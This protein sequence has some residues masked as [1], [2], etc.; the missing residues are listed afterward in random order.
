MPRRHRTHISLHQPAMLSPCFCIALQ[1]NYITRTI[2]FCY[3]NPRFS[4]V[5]HSDNICRKTIF[6]KLHN[7]RYHSVY[8]SDKG[9]LEIQRLRRSNAASGWSKGTMCLNASKLSTV[10]NIPRKKYTPS[11]EDSSECNVSGSEPS[12]ACATDRSGELTAAE[13][14]PWN[15]FRGDVLELE[16]RL[17]NLKPALVAHV[18]THHI[19]ESVR[20]TSERRVRE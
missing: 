3:L 17:Q 8:S 9:V 10:T 20:T 14:N 2:F 15:G 11:L 5:S 12:T 7:V 19:C 18:V 16:R 13:S 4:D 6:Y 1:L